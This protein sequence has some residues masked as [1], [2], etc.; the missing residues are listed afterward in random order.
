MLSRHNVKNY[1][2]NEL[3]GNSSRNGRLQSSQLAKP[4]WADR[5]LTSETGVR[6]LISTLKKKIK[7]Q[8]GKDTSILPQKLLACQD[9]KAPMQS[10]KPLSALQ[11]TT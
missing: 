2:G 1:Q 4:L 11:T 3:T 8:A 10:L 7:A 6:E 9:K 5:G